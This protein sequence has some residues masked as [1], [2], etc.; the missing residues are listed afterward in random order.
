MVPPIQW[1]VRV[2]F[3]TLFCNDQ[4]LW[5]CGTR[6]L[7]DMLATTSGTLEIWQR[8]VCDFFSLWLRACH[9]STTIPFFSEPYFK[10]IN[11]HKTSWTYSP[12]YKKL[13]G[14]LD[15]PAKWPDCYYSPESAFATDQFSWLCEMKRFGLIDLYQRYSGTWFSWG[16]GQFV[17][18]VWTTN[19]SKNISGITSR[20]ISLKHLLEFVGSI[21][22]RNGVCFLVTA[23]NLIK[24]F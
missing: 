4:Y 8:P 15:S 2:F 3:W 6:A 9:R 5:F 13:F 18:C 14:N 17:F 19:S 7:E 23:H 1:S 12:L 24:F 21:F 22:V 11:R 16:C 20:R 10:R